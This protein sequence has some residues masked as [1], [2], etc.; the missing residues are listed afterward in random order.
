MEH[1]PVQPTPPDRPEPDSAWHRLRMLCQLEIMRR[2]MGTDDRSNATFFAW[3]E[4]GH[5]KTFAHIVDAQ[6]EDGEHIRRLI[7]EDPETAYTH[8]QQQMLH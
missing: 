8:I 6:D 7:A 3:T 4:Q 2:V 5:A 1:P